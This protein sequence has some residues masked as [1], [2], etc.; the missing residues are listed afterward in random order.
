MEKLTLA[1][2]RE[3]FETIVCGDQ[4]A[5]TKP[6]PDIYL[7]AAERTTATVA[8]RSQDRERTA[9]PAILV[10][11]PPVAATNAAKAPTTPA[12]GSS[13]APRGRR[14]IRPARGPDARRVRRPYR[15]VSCPHE[16]TLFF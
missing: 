6:A 14:V 16:T 11:I 15:C 13:M 9:I 12:S 2:I 8:G 10:S 1:G 7:S 4:V 3:R 5:K